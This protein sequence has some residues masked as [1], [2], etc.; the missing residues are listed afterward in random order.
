MIT[1]VQINRC[2]RL[3]ESESI[4]NYESRMVAEVK[5]YWI[6]YKQCSGSQIDLPETKDILQ[7]WRHKWHA[8][9]GMQHTLVSP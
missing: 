2:S 6:I 3:I 1:E 9:F 4:T 5:L 7:S 8:L